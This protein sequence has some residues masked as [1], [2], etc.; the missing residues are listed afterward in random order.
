MGRF[1][2]IISTKD[3]LSKRALEEN[4]LNYCFHESQIFN[5]LESAKQ[6]AFNRHPNNTSYYVLILNLDRL[7]GIKYVKN[8]IV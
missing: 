1:V 4:V 8:K 7:D 5:T 6:E 2:L 3:T